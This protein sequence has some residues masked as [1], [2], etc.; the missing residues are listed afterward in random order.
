MKTKHLLLFV[1]AFMIVAPLHAQLIKPYKTDTYT[2]K[3]L[4]FPTVP[5]NGERARTVHINV[6]KEAR[7]GGG[8]KKIKSDSRLG[9]LTSAASKVVD[10]E[11]GAISDKDFS[12]GKS[13]LIPDVFPAE[14]DYYLEVSVSSDMRAK[15]LDLEE[16]LLDPEAHSANKSIGAKMEYK[17][18]DKPEGQSNRNLIHSDGPYWVVGE[19]EGD[20]MAGAEAKDNSRVDLAKRWAREEVLNMYGLRFSYFGVPVYRVKGLDRDEKNKAKDKQEELGSLIQSF[21]SKHRNE[22]Y[23]NK[24]KKNLAFWEKMLKQHQPGETKTRKAA[25]N[26]EN[27]WTVYSNLAVA[28]FLLGNETKTHSYLDKAIKRNFIDWKETTNNKGEVIGRSRVGVYDTES[29]ANLHIFKRMADSYFPGIKAMNP[30][31]INFLADKEARQKASNTAREWGINVYLSQLITELDV[32]VE[33][34]SSEIGNEQPKQITG[35]INQ[36]GNKIADYTIKKTFLFPLTNSYKINIETTDGS[37]ITNQKNGSIMLPKCS[38][39]PYFNLATR[40]YTR[41]VDTDSQGK[42]RA[43]SGIRVMYDFDGNIILENNMLREKFMYQQFVGTNKEDALGYR[44]MTYQFTLED[45]LSVKS[46][47]FSTERI[48]RNRESGLGAFF[49]A[50]FDKMVDPNFVLETDVQFEEDHSGTYKFSDEEIITTT[51][52]E[53]KQKNVYAEKNEKN[54]WT[55]MT[56]GETEISRTIV[57]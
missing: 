4:Q 3:R 10:D 31:F 20:M 48:D 40:L 37:V 29:I 53:T 1:L 8:G 30:N 16:I 47:D 18:Y 19:G 9:K 26:D 39:D 11:A 23:K 56:I 32:P 15:H 51:H 36:N 22:E 12:G 54:H 13:K 38:Y 43:G 17:L 28:N 57:Y 52:G 45:D 42:W 27:V 2:L 55:K 25:V 5:Q 14:G 33:F 46:V 41:D 6:T 24:V 7:I 21:S 50:T 35:T 49:G 44:D 34:V